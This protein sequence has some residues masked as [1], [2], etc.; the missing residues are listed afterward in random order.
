MFALGRKTAETV[1]GFLLELFSGLI[2]KEL[3]LGCELQVMHPAIGLAGNALQHSLATQGID[4]L[5][6]VALMARQRLAERRHRCPLLGNLHEDRS[7]AQAQLTILECGVEHFVA[8]VCGALEQMAETQGAIHDSA[9]VPQ[10]AGVF[11]I[12]HTGIFE[13]S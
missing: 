5:R 2:A 10:V 9:I 12:L 4:N 7:L 13:Y 3:A 8:P 1:I 11:G 6:D